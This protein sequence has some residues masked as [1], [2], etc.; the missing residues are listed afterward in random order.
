MD[1]IILGGGIVG[2][3][4]ANLLAKNTALKITIVD[5][6]LELSDWD[7]CNY[8]LRCSAINRA[9]QNVFK[10]I[11]I[12]Q[13]LQNTRF[14]VYEKMVVWQD[15]QRNQIDFNAYECNEVN[16]GHIIENRLIQRALL[17]KLKAYQN[18]HLI[19]GV[20]SKLEQHADYMSIDVAE[21][22]LNAKL[23]IGADGANSWLRSTIG[24]Q[25]YTSDYK[26]LALV[27]SIKSDLPHSNTAWQKFTATGTIAF[28]PLD[29]GNMS[30]L[31]WAADTA[32]MQQM[33]VADP[34]DFC[35]VLAA[36]FNHKLGELEL[37][38][39]RAGFPL[40]LLHA[41][42]YTAPRVALVGD[43]AHV[44]HPLAGQGL[45]L[46]IMDAAAL[47]EII[48]QAIAQKRDFGS[49]T[50]LRKYERWRKGY[51]MSMMGVF[52]LFN[53]TF[54]RQS[55]WLQTISNSSIH[56]LNSMHIVKR[57]MANFAMGLNEDLP[58]SAKYG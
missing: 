42:S 50:V 24:I 41:H 14:G 5:V 48:Q 12:W 34:A 45:N 44:V 13:E 11:G 1:V 27:A 47:S 28:L 40:K 19:Y 9:T 49:V 2:L 43:A 10:H 38:G 57:S 21:Q 55:A 25:C 39:Q 32:S 54:T 31:V 16:L 52:D 17:H 53:R 30:S 3:T 36:E 37:I 56:L 22:Q 7:E 15:Q 46:G 4:M 33:L 18:V 29:K 35:R 23:I 58:Q 8:D 20:A 6:K 26:Q 51:N